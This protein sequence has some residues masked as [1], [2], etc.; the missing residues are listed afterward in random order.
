LSVCSCS[1]TA[2]T[3]AE[4]TVSGELGHVRMNTRFHCAHSVSVALASGA[5]RTVQTPF[6]GNGYVHEAIEA[7]RCLRAGLRES[8]RMPLDETLALMGVLD[9]IRRQIGLTYAADD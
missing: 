8:A 4:L 1:L 6:L 9:D 5:T 7:G 2:R 3:P